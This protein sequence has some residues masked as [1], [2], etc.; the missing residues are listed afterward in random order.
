MQRG[1]QPTFAPPKCGGSPRRRRRNDD[2]LGYMRSFFF[3]LAS[4]VIAGY[5]HAKPQIPDGGTLKVHIERNG[6]HRILHIEVGHVVDR[7]KTTWILSTK[8]A[9]PRSNVALRH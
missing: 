3:L 2:G 6:F 8:L 4:L 9:N 5:V 1:L 7:E